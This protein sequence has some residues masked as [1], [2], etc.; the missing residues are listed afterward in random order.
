MSRICGIAEWLVDEVHC[1]KVERSV[2]AF[3]QVFKDILQGRIDLAPLAGD[4]T[5][6]LWRDFH[7]DRWIG[8]VEEA[9]QHAARQS[10]RGA[11]T[12]AEAYRLA[13]LAEKL[14]LTLIQEPAAPEITFGLVDQTIRAGSVS[15]G[16]QI[17]R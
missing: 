5:A 3:A 1:L 12:A 8:R 17:R 2:E 9:L 16:G 4:T 11:G 7:L 6:A 13:L 15:D 14:T 10:R